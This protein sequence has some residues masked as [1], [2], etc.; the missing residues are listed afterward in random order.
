MNLEYL[1]QSEQARHKL[2][3]RP[4]N[5]LYCHIAAAEDKETMS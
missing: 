2:K 5:D 4:W 1:Q 3:G